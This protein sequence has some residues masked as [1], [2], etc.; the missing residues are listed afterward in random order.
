MSSYCNP[1][2]AVSRCLTEWA[3]MANWG[4][5]VMVLQGARAWHSGAGTSSPKLGLGPA[6]TNKSARCCGHSLES[7]GC[8][9]VERWM[10]SD[11]T[12]RFVAEPWGYQS[13]WVWA[14]APWSVRRGFLEQLAH[15]CCHCRC[16]LAA[17]AAV[18]GRSRQPCVQ[19]RP[20]DQGCCHHCHRQPTRPAR[21][22]P[23]A[24]PPVPPSAPRLSSTAVPPVDEQGV[25]Q[26]AD[27]HGGGWH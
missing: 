7:R 20:S 2:Y 15:C 14:G 3:A 5:T 6:A 4:A 10:R 1:L 11:V 17:A 18:A 23:S 25:R 19:P 8:L 13:P 16:H 12:R 26:A 27:K 24:Q 21:L 22:Q 9:A